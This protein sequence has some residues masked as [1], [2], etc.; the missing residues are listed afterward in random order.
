MDII[1]SNV[2]FNGEL[3]PLKKVDYLIIHHTQSKT[4]S[5]EQIHQWHLNKK[6]KGIGYNF[7]IRKNGDI[8]ECRGFNE[9]AQARGYNDKSL[10]IALE[11]NFMIEKPTEEQI[12]S[13]IDFC[14]FLKQKYPNVEIREHK[15]VNDT[16]CAGTN[17]NIDEIRYKVNDKNYYKEKLIEIR[18]FINEIINYGGI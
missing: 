11:G 10:G 9:G 14:K 6:W 1:K 3:I 17:F 12:K 15:E 18:D 16:D 13:L 8:Y 4:A 2:K 5:V 7:Y